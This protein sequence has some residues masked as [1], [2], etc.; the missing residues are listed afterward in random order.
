M[1]VVEC[2]ALALEE[3][4]DDLV[5]EAGGGWGLECDGGLIVCMNQFQ[6]F[7]NV[8][9]IQQSVQI[10]IF[11]KNLL[12]NLLMECQ[13]TFQR[14]NIPMSSFQVCDVLNIF[15][16][17]EKPLIEHLEGFIFLSKEGDKLKNFFRTLNWKFQLRNLKVFPHWI[18]KS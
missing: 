17:L 15:F 2:T 18:N 9:H 10:S 14:T 13:S 8:V 11:C 7:R 16:K 5:G 6:L 1:G 12:Q 4:C 3:E